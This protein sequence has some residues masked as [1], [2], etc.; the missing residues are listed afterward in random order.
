M[1]LDCLAEDV[2]DYVGQMTTL[3]DFARALEGTHRFHGMRVT[4]LVLAG[5]RERV[6]EAYVNEIERRPRRRSIGRRWVKTQRDV[7][8]ARHKL[9]MCGISLQGGRNR[10]GT[11][12]R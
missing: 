10:Q 3:G 9:D 12:A 7:H 11:Q 4:A 8:G 5:E 6:A 2:F 1:L